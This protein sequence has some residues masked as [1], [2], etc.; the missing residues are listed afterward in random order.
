MKNNF[1]THSTLQEEVYLKYCNSEE[2][3]GLV[4]LELYS[5]SFPF[6]FYVLNYIWPVKANMQTQIN[7]LE[8]LN[9]VCGGGT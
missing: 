2:P 5:F 3:K 4:K 6:S 7:L 1:E 8:V 9:G